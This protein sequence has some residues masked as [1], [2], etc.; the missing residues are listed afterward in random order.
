M[1]ANGDNMASLGLNIQRFML[2]SGAE[3]RHL[4]NVTDS[5]SDSNGDVMI[6]AVSTSETSVT[7][8]NITPCNIPEDWPR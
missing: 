5:R 2:S 6:K 7:Y 4:K 8:H 1:S 3:N